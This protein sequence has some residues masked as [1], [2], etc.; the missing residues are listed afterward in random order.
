MRAR[1][2]LTA[3]LCALASACVTPMADQQPSLTNIQLLR[4]GEMPS[5]ALG[6]FALAPGLPTRMDRSISIRADSV[7]APG[8]GSFS[9]YL[10]QTLETELRAAGKL[11]PA[12]A[13]IISAQL[14]QSHVSTGTPANGTLGARFH[15]ER[16]GQTLFDR[17]VVV[18]DQWESNFIGA[19]AIPMA[20]DRYTALYQ[21]LVTQLLSDDEFRAAVRAS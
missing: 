19:V 3:L 18:G 9:H 4:T 1:T 7:T 12:S 21:R 17:E 16:H 15:V 6:D 20:M 14:T 8:D 2:L 11:D 13:T 5:F 10:R